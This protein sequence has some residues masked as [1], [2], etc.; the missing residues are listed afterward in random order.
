MRSLFD[1]DFSNSHISKKSKLIPGRILLGLLL[2][3]I[4]VYNPIISAFFV[5]Y[6]NSGDFGFRLGF[7]AGFSDFKFSSL[8]I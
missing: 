3:P 2:N 7:E 8:E 1:W 6:I 5:L 4:K